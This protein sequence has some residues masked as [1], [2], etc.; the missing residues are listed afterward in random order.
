M[1]ITTI[2]SQNS[3]KPTIFKVKSENKMT[4]RSQHPIQRTIK[5]QEIII[6]MARYC[7]VNPLTRTLLK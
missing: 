4:S 1:Q 7:S 2:I 5:H 3:C 6:I